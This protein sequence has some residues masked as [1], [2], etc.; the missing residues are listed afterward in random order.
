MQTYLTCGLM[1]LVRSQYH[2][3][4]SYRVRVRQAQQ[5]VPE[6]VGL[7]TM[8]TRMV[9]TWRERGGS[10]AA[11]PVQARQRGSLR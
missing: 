3:R 7:Y 5:S 1:L 6:K 11:I 2:W 8:F 9:R 10:Q 4:Y